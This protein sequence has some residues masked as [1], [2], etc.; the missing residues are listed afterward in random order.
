MKQPI[1]VVGASGTL[2]QEVVQRLEGAGYPTRHATRNPD[3]DPSPGQNKVRF[4]WDS[5]LTFLPAV[6]GVS[7][8][9]LTVRPLDLAA[10]VVVPGFLDECRRTGVEHVVLVSALGADEERAGPLGLLES[11]L[12]HSGL[13][14][15]ILRPNFYMENFSHG[16]LRP[17]IQAAGRICVP[18][19]QGRT[20]FVSVADVADV[21]ARVLEDE[22]LRGQAIDLTGDDPMSHT[23]VAAALTRASQRPVNYHPLTDDE[24]R[25]RG[26][27]AGMPA[28]AMEY[29][30]VLYALV[31]EGL[32]ERRS[33]RI[34]EL[35]GRKPRS[36][37][38]FAAANVDAWRVPATSRG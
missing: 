36:F 32:A 35:L 27:R 11:V 28:G 2:G 19:E 18:A 16:W 26:R 6:E 37:D 30:L 34:G 9:F 15:T 5:P 13:G 7:Q 14:W 1:L 20:S 22:S 17:E 24:M 31:R 3:R 21:A 8:V 33:P 10:A 25:E 29:L 23:A 4:S 12:R 38:D